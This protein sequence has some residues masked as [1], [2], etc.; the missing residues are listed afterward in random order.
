[1]P[2][3]IWPFSSSM[4][5]SV[6][7]FYRKHSIA[8]DFLWPRH[9]TKISWHINPKSQRHAEMQRSRQKF[10]H[11]YY[12]P[13]WRPK[14]SKSS[15]PAMNSWKSSSAYPHYQIASYVQVLRSR[16]SACSVCFLLD[17]SVYLFLRKSG[18]RVLLLLIYYGRSSFHSKGHA[19]MQRWIDRNTDIS[20]VVVE[21]GT[22]QIVASSYS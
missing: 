11:T 21:T 5:L 13:L 14:H 22:Q 3:W 10:R 7:L 6:E 12:T 18:P 20:P 1:M 2:E 8:H 4:E 15:P 19:E 9:E 16:D 17:C